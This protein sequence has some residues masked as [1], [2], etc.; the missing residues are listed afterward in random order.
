MYYCI[1]PQVKDIVIR[2]FHGV[3]E[4]FHSFL[5]RIGVYEGRT[6]MRMD[7]NDSGTTE[8]AVKNLRH[9]KVN[10]I[11]AARWLLFFR[12]NPP[13]ENSSQ[14]CVPAYLTGRTRNVDA[15]TILGNLEPHRFGPLSESKARR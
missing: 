7:I 6:E 9:L 10:R 4:V 13:S 1:T 12:S 11:D 14:V 3:D 15:S 8:A 2:P 5:E